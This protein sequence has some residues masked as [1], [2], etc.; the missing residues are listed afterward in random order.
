MT[1]GIQKANFWKRFSA[2]LVDTVAVFFVALGVFILACLIVNTDGIFKAYETKVEPYK[3][4]VETDY[5][6]DLD[7]VNTEEYRKMEQADREAYDALREKAQTALNEKIEADKEA[8]AL[9]NEWFTK[10]LTSGIV[11]LLTSHLL[12]N[13]CLPLI[14]KNGQTLGKKVFNLGVM[15]TNGV[16]V[17]G[18]AL[19]SRQFVGLCAIETLAVIFM[20]SLGI[21]GLIAALLVQVLQIGVMIKTDTNSS[22]HDLLADTVVIELSSQQIF[23]TEEERAQFLAQESTENASPD[24]ESAPPQT[25]ESPAVDGNETSADA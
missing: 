23:E 2:W 22:I 13:F 5:S 3:I 4:A 18:V 14:L 12:L 21:V 25:A 7:F 8:V 1:I 16:K 6:I 10:N 20:C 11:A 17:S 19:F 15:R 9:Y 24:E